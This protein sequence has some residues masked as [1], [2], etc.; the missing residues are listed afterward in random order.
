[1]INIR[2]MIC[3][4]KIQDVIIINHNPEKNSK[5]SPKSLPPNPKKKLSYIT[6]LVLVTVPALLQQFRVPI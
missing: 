3:L 2:Q 5:Y 1:M 6:K 4:P